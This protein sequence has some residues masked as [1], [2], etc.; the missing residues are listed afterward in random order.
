MTIQKYIRTLIKN[1]NFEEFR[2]LFNDKKIDPSW[3]ENY[4]IRYACKCG[5]VEIVKSLLNDSRVDPSANYNYC[6]FISVQIGNL[7]IVKLLLSHPTINPTDCMDSVFCCAVQLGHFEIA[8]VLLIDGRIDPSE[9]NNLPI[10]NAYKNKVNDK[11]ILTLLWQN[12]KIKTSLKND[13]IHLYNKLI[14]MDIKNKI[15]A[16]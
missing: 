4:A 5:H 13:D 1:N 9:F 12:N 6:L 15:G 2:L 10:K 11:D 16:F 7:D 3:D 14:K 8:N